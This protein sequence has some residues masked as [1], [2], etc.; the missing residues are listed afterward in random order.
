MNDMQLQ[1]YSPPVQLF[2]ANTSYYKLVAPA[3]VSTAAMATGPNL[4]CQAQFSVTL[5]TRPVVRVSAHTGVY[6]TKKDNLSPTE[7]A[8]AIVQ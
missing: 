3:Q 1:L 5:T 2:P 4:L 7:A 8:D 6:V